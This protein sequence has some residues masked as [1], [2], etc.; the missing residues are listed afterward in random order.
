MWPA[1][2]WVSLGWYLRLVVG[3]S[4]ESCD[5][6]NG[7]SG[8]KLRL[9]LP[10]LAVVGPKL[11]ILLPPGG[12]CCAGLMAMGNEVDFFGECCCVG[13]GTDSGVVTLA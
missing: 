2:R 11:C 4:G 3:D 12:L 5:S 6:W 13:T 7:E 10:R 8:D 1:L 9:L